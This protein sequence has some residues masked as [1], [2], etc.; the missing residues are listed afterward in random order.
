MAMAK[1]EIY[2]TLN[3]IEKGDFRVLEEFRDE[4]VKSV[5]AGV[6]DPQPNTKSSSAAG[7]KSK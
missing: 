2:A 7:D 6:N 5:K 4:F 1:E 3:R